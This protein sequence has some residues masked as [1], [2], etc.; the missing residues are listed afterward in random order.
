MADPLNVPSPA[1]ARPHDYPARELLRTRRLRLRELCYRDVP[2]LWRMGREPR[3]AAHLLD[4]P[5][6]TISAACA[7]VD[8]A[9]GVYARRPGLGLWRAEDGGGRFVGFFSLMPEPDADE[10][11]IGCRLL[12][13][14]WGRGYALEGGAALCTH[15][16]ATLGLPHLVGVCAPDNRSVPPLLL[17]LGFRA[18]GA[19]AQAGKPAL[20]FVLPRAEWRGI[21]SRRNHA[22][23]APRPAAAD[24]A[25]A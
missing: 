17:R 20:R 18:D 15:A 9:N 7:L 16:F 5:V 25:A 11:G 3:V 10:V 21:R 8:M 12:P 6:S 1:P 23:P 24:T 22:A 19:T 13:G 2:E 4:S 14:A